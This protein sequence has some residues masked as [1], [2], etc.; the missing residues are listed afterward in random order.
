MRGKRSKTETPPIHRRRAVFRGRADILFTFIPTFRSRWEPEDVG[1]TRGP[2]KD[3]GCIHGGESREERWIYPDTEI[4]ASMLSTITHRTSSMERRAIFQATL[5]YVYRGRTYTGVRLNAYTR[6][7]RE[8]AD[9]VLTSNTITRV[10]V[11]VCM[12]GCKQRWWVKF[13]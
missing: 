7:C 1:G 11:C 6:G 3:E 13:S 9:C 10:C 5:S 4:F 2:Y 12:C 8:K